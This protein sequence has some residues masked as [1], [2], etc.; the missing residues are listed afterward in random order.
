MATS[1]YLRLWF[2]SVCSAPLD[3]RSRICSR[4]KSREVQRRNGEMTS[5]MALLSPA[6]ELKGFS[7]ALFQTHLQVF[8]CASFPRGFSFLEALRKQALEGVS[9]ASVILIPC[10][11]GKTVLG[12]R[13][14]IPGL[15]LFRS[16][17]FDWGTCVTCYLILG[18]FSYQMKFKGKNICN[19]AIE[20]R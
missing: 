17:N 10:L 20:H 5:V 19:N 14:P 3:S 13:T 7:C 9:T 8:F 15:L 1:P 4:I 12:S 18:K 11:L 2:N 16:W 6:L